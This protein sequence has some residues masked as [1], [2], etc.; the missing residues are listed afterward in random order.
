MQF[1]AL[2][3][4]LY[5]LIEYD[6]IRTNNRMIKSH[7]LYRWTTYSKK[8]FSKKWSFKTRMKTGNK[9]IRVYIKKN[10]LKNKNEKNEI[11]TRN[12]QLDK[13]TFKPIKL[14][15]QYYEIQFSWNDL[16]V[17]ANIALDPKSNMYTNFI[18]TE[19]DFLRFIGIEPIIIA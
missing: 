10:A 14:F 5:N 15:S 11:W 19:K 16:N 6:W 4:M 13:L 7:M 12:L 18:T 3:I 17:H 1:I 2:P 9:T 8:P